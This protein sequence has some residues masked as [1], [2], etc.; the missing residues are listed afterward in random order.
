[1]ANLLNLSELL[2]ST[3]TVS[4]SKYLLQ[5]GE[6]S[7]VFEGKTALLEGRL[8]IPETLQGT[9]I[10]LLGH[11]HSLQG[12]TMN[13][14]VVTTMAR[15]FRELGIPSLRFNFRGVEQSGGVFDNGPGESDDMLC[16]AR[17]WA[18]LVPNNRFIFAGFSFGSYVA[19]RAAAQWPHDLL[20]SIAPPVMRYD[21]DQFHPA[22]AVWHIVQG[23]KD[24]VVPAEEVVAFAEQSTPPLSVHYFP[25]AGHFFHGGLLELKACL[26]AISRQ[27]LGLS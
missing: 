16:L 23:E 26:L 17:L 11:P 5:A 10:A 15:A 19:Y 4:F 21:Y 7:F 12:G 27:E 9:F 3:P 1:M 13:N 25:Q 22:P 8:L 18:T 14:K 24:E 20:I 2:Q 6:H